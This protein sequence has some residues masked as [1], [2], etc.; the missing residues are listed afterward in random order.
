MADFP[1]PVDMTT[2]V[3]RPF[4]ID[5]IASRCPGRKVTKPNVSRATESIGGLD[6][7]TRSLP[8]FEGQLTRARLIPSHR[9]P[10]RSSVRAGPRSRPFHVV[11]DVLEDVLLQPAACVEG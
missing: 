3:S 7:C 10:S 11:E 9:N 1:E 4:R 8:A 2:S 5:S 6:I